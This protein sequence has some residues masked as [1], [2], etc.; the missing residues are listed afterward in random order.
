VRL[1]SFVVSVNENSPRRI[2]RAE[3]F[4]LLAGWLG[5]ISRQNFSPDRKEHGYFYWTR[6]SKILKVKIGNDLTRS[7]DSTLQRVGGPIE[8]PRKRSTSF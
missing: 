7:L 5:L 4:G 6:R 2:G 8:Q 3:N 1:L